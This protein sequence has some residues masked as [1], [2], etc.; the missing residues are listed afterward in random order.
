MNVYKKSYGQ[1]S[2]KMLD[3]LKLWN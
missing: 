2:K 1:S 3:E